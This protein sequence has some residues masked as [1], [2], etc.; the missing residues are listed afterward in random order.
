MRKAQHIS[1]G[2]YLLCN[3]GEGAFSSERVVD[4]FAIASREECDF[5]KGRGGVIGYIGN[6]LKLNRGGNYSL[7]G[8]ES[9]TG[10]GLI[11]CSYV[12]QHKKG[13][14]WVGIPNQY[15]H[16]ISSFLVPRDSIQYIREGDR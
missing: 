8:R 12:R 10:E 9:L 13:E 1:E 15:G 11:K 3:Y 14:L 2:W 6:I 16:R 4:F 7:L 5:S